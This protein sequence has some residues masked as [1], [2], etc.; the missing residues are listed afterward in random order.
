MAGSGLLARRGLLAA[1][2]ALSACAAG[3]DAPDK[4]K[5]EPLTVITAAGSHAFEVEIADND[6]ER[7]LGLM[8][9]DSI[10]PDR[11]MLFVFKPPRDVAFWMKN[12]RI[13]LDMIF[14]GQDGR[15]VNIAA[16]ATPYSLDPV[17]SDGAVLGVLE[18]AG[19]RAAELHIEP[20]DR[21]RHRVFPR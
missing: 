16:N 4:V 19:G 5:L 2:L 6:Q 13:P 9:R 20:G 11:G 8:Y 12:T 3:A 1:L 18:I 14:I 7:A 17:P 21:V 15:I 10:A